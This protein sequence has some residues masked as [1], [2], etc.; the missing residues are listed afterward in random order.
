MRNRC[1]PSDRL[2]R[3]GLDHQ[4]R[5]SFYDQEKGSIEH[6]ILQCIFVREVWTNVCLAMNKP[7]WIPTSGSTLV[8]WCNDKNGSN[9]RKKDTR[10]IIM[11]VMWE[12][13]K[14]RNSIVFDGATPSTRY[15]AQ[16]I[17]VEGRAWMVAG[18]LRD[19]TQA[20]LVALMVGNTA[21][22]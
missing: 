9:L 1:W 3:R 14:H 22:S 2:A 4:E 12:L 21:R 20:F 7:A 18:L 6:I 11:L 5:C 17:E 8:E 13:W 16:R 19:D 15:L 10:A